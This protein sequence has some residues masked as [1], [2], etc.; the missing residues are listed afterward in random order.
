MLSLTECCWEFQHNV[1]WDGI[2]INMPYLCDNLLMIIKFV[3][4]LAHE[5]GAARTEVPGYKLSSFIYE[6]EKPV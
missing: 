5:K 1:M 6:A 4:F 3:S 2:L